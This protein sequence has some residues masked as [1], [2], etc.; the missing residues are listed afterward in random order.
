M[1]AER[2]GRP[3]LYS[4]DIPYLFYK[5]EELGPKSAGMKDYLYSITE[6]GLNSW[7]EAILAYKSQIPTLGDAM[8]PP[9]Q[10]QES[11]RSYWGEREGIRLFNMLQGQITSL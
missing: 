2:V 11:I 1:G 10:A 4:I 8:F 3:L 9:E 7:Q 5:P 6:A